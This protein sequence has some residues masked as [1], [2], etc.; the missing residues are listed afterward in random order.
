M[1]DSQSDPDLDE[2]PAVHQNQHGV[3]VVVLLLLCTDYFLAL[4]ITALTAYFTHGLPCIIE[5]A[6][7]GHW[8]IFSNPG[9]LK[10]EINI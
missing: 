10:P 9:S 5:K 6:L 4:F 3:L 8:L 2:E 7:Y 1:L